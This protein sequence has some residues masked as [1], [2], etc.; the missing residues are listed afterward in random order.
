MRQ[1]MT[2]INQ[3]T[4]TPSEDSRSA[5]A[6]AQSDQSS[7]SGCPGLSESSPSTLRS[8][9][10]FAIHKAS[11]E[12]SYLTGRMP[13]F[14]QSL[15]WSHRSFC[16]FCRAPVHLECVIVT[17][18]TENQYEPR[19]DKTSKMSVPRLIRVFAVRSMGS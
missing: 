14:D 19:H 5:W 10:S 13:R 16:W 18:V 4:C 12:G 11:S 15:R 1:S 3:M 2:K 6:S 9:G 17:H 7:P 8:S